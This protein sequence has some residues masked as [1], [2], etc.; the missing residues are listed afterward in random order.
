[1]NWEKRAVDEVINLEERAAEVMVE[2]GFL[3]HRMFEESW[4]G[5]D[6]SWFEDK[7]SELDSELSDIQEALGYDKP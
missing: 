4:F 6:L 5:G 3:E 7:L 1:M 2:M